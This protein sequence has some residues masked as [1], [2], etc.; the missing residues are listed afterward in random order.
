MIQRR[1]SSASTD[2]RRPATTRR[3]AGLVLGLSALVVGLVA[4]ASA[5]AATPTVAATDGSTATACTGGAWPWSVQGAPAFGAGSAAGE[6]LWHSP[7]GWHLRVTHPGTYLAG[8]S[9]TIRANKPLHVTGYRLE[10]G[11][12][13]TVS[14]DGLSVSYRFKNYGALD[15][16][17]FT[18]ECA[19]RLGVSA[20]MN[21]ALL[22]ARRIWVGHTGRHPL[23]NPFVIL[24][25]A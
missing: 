12:A 17:D 8:F 7:T 20:R 4:P 22:P 18:T 3:L 23:G 21:G 19:T 11:D 15:G 9:G 24:R 10:T 25:R 5:F 2:P 16:I 6:R 1:T 13:F 14:A